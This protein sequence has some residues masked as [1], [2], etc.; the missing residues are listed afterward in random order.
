MSSVKPAEERIEKWS[1]KLDPDSPV[2]M[3]MQ[4]KLMV[5]ALVEVENATRR[6]LFT[7]PIPVIMV[8][9]Y[10]NFAR[11]M[12]KAKRTYLGA[13]FELE[14]AVRVEKYVSRRLDRKVLADI[15]RK[16]FGHEI[17]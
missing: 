17:G 4:G 2:E 6:V 7:H 8:P 14:A 10:L 12:W 11:E 16:V 1:R 9:W 15:C 3:S 5:E 13:T